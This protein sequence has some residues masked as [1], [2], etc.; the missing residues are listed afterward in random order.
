VENIISRSCYID[1]IRLNDATAPSC[2]RS[3]YF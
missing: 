3:P 2:A 1:Q